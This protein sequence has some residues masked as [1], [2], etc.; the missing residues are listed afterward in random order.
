[1]ARSRAQG[2][3]SA[4]RSS[5]QLRRF[6]LPINVDKVFGTHRGPSTTMTDASAPASRFSR[7]RKSASL[8]VKSSGSTSTISGPRHLGQKLLALDK[9]SPALGWTHILSRV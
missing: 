6:Y 9:D 4:A 8:K 2:I 7:L 1:M 5:P 3:N